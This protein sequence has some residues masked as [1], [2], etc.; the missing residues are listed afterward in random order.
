VKETTKE[1]ESSRVYIDR[2]YAD[3][4]AKD[5]DRRGPPSKEIAAEFERKE[6][7]WMEL[8]RGYSARIRELEGRLAGR[9]SAGDSERHDAVSMDAY[10]L[11]ARQTRRYKAES[12]KHERTAKKLEETV[13]RL[14]EQLDAVRTSSTARGSDGGGKSLKVLRTIESRRAADREGNDE[15]AAPS[16]PR[17]PS[18]RPADEKPPQQ[19]QRRERGKQLSRVAAVKAAGGRKGL[20]EQLKRSRRFG[21]NKALGAGA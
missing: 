8:E 18:R 12:A 2:L 21:E 19:Q 17:E 4:Q 14:R 16:D 1:L 13:G 10:L 5:E 9:S 3:L 20:S 11:E 6:L 15:N 7:E